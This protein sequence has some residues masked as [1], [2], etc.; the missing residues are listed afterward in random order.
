MLNM[1]CHAYFAGGQGIDYPV[2]GTESSLS[3]VQ[4]WDEDGKV[5]VISLSM[6]EARELIVVEYPSPTMENIFRDLSQEGHQT[7]TASPEDVEGE[8]GIKG[9]WGQG[10]LIDGG[11]K[12]E[13][14]AD[15]AREEGFPERKRAA[16]N[17]G[18]TQP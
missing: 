16:C 4:L 5:K 11:Y 8:R 2:L 12:G 13:V 9:C 15:Q 14:Q 17:A 18:E 7:N 3:Y 1:L 6:M 10:S